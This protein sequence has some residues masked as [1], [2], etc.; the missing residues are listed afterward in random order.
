MLECLKQ[1]S[2]LNSVKVKTK[3]SIVLAHHDDVGGLVSPSPRRNQFVR[4]SLRLRTPAPHRN[5]ADRST[6]RHAPCLR[7]TFFILFVM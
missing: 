4:P 1:L 5:M 6:F 7:M 3:S 2:L